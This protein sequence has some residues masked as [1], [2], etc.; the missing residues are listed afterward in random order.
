MSADLGPG[1]RR[2][3]FGEAVSRFGDEIT[4][5]ALPW[6]V[7]SDTG[8]PLAV[9]ALEAF[10][11]LP[12]V[13]FGLVIGVVADRRP[14]RRSMIQADLVRVVLLATV[15]LVVL[16]DGSAPLAQVLAVAFCAGLAKLL[17]D[18]SAQ[19]FVAD[20]VPRSELVPANSRVA[21]TDGAATIAGP[22]LAGLLIAIAGAAGAVAVDAGT[23]AVSAMAVALVVVRRDTRSQARPGMGAAVKEG[24]RFIARQPV[25]LASTCLSTGVNLAGGMFSALVVIFLQQTVGLSGWEA[26]IVFA[27]NG[28]GIMVASRIAPRLARSGLGR[29][30]LVGT[31]IAAAGF[32]LFAATTGS[33]WELTAVGGM[34]LIGL[35]TGFALIA[36]ASLRQRL[37]PGELL[38]RVTASSAVV[39]RGAVPV[40]AIVGGAIGEVAGIR[41]GL[42]TL[43]CLYALV[44]VGGALS[45]LRGSDPA[46]AEA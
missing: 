34:A 23:F 28:V 21:L 42:V 41:A 43:A 3:W 29:T 7:A 18:S 1:F 44:A 8:S 25:L 40:G 6:M 16:A 39:F 24:I 26:G 30:I 14:R 11:F 35:G 31:G 45:P 5:L 13:L 22:G 27:A 46:P 9:G 20:L 17:F 4:I 15:P 10:A 38:G 12:I 33:L 37:V 32:L 36:N 2:Y 19:A